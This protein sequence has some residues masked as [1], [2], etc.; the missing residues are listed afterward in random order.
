MPTNK[1]AN[2]FKGGLN[3][4]VDP[5]NQPKDTYSYALNLTKEDPVN[6]ADIVTNE[7]GFTSYLDLEYVYT[8]IGSVW[9]GLENYIL[10]IKSPLGSGSSFNRIIYLSNQ[11]PTTIYDNINLNFQESNPIKGTY[12]TNFKNQRIIYWVDGL[13]DDRVINVDNYSSYLNNVTELSLQVFYK[14][15]ILTSSVINDSG[16]SLA[17]GTLEFYGAYKTKDNAVSSWFRLTAN[18]LYII[19]DSTQSLSPS[20]Y[21]A[22]DGC[23]SGLPTNKSVTLNIS[24]LDPA[25]SILQIGVLK[26][27]GGN[28]KGF[29]VD[30]IYYSSS[31]LS[32]S[33][34]GDDTE[35]LVPD[36]S[37][38]VINPVRYYASNSIIQI[39][40]RLLRAN[41]S[42]NK[43]DIGYQSF[44]NNIV[45]DYYVQEELVGSMPDSLDYNIRQNWWKSAN[46]KYTGTK[47]LMRDEVYSVGIAF[48]LIK[49]NTESEVY[50]IPG[51][52]I[53][54]IPNTTYNN[55]YNNTSTI[56]YSSTWDTSSITENGITL[57]SWKVINTAASSLD[58]SVKKCAYWESSSMYPSNLSLPTTGSSSTGAGTTPIR[59][60]KIPNSGLEPIFRSTT[61]GGTINFYKRNIGLNFSN[62]QVPDSLKGNIAYIRIYIT[63]RNTANNKSIIAKGI[64]TNCALTKINIGNFSTVSTDLYVRPCAPYNDQLEVTNAGCYGAG[65]ANG[66]DTTHNYYHS[67]Y[68]PDT[69]LAQPQVTSNKVTIENEFTGTVQY[70][71]T[72]ASLINADPYTAGG[73]GHT[74]SSTTPG[75]FTGN[76]GYVRDIFYDDSNAG[77]TLPTGQT[78]SKLIYNVS[79]GVFRTTY[80]SICILNNINK[81]ATANSRRNTKQSVYVPFNANLSTSQL[82]NMDNPYISEYGASNVLVELDP[83]YNYLGATVTLDNSVAFQDTDA[84][85]NYTNPAQASNVNGTFHFH[86]INS[87]TAVYRYGSLKKVNSSQYGTMDGLVYI[88]TDTVISNPTFDAN[89]ILTTPLGGL[90]GDCWIDM[91]SV[92]RTRYSQIQTY[93]FGGFPEISIGMSTFFTESNI[94]HRLR[95]AEG[96]DYKQYYPKQ[97]LTTSIKQYLDAGFNLNI[98]NVDNYYKQNTDFNKLS[99]YRNYGLSQLD[100]QLFGITNYITRI[101]YSNPLLNESLVDNYR[102]YL[103]N[104]YIDLPKD[105]GFI[106]NMFKRSQELYAI[107]RD[108]LWR[109]Y[110]SNETIKSDTSTI[111]VGTGEFF[112]LSPIETLSIDGGFGGSS[113]KLS[114]AECP[115]GYFYVDKNKGKLILF[116]DRQ[117]YYDNSQQVDLS[118]LGIFEFIKDNFKISSP[119]IVDFDT[120]L[121]NNGYVA[122]YDPQLKRILVTRLDYQLTSAQKSAYRGIFNPLTSYTIGDVYFKNGQYYTYSSTSTSYSTVDSSSNLSDFTSG[123]IDTIVYTNTSPT[124]GTVTV[125]DNTTLTYTPTTNYTGADAFNITMNCVTTTV[126]VT[127]NASAP[128]SITENFRIINNGGTD[129]YVNILMDGVYQT[130]GQLASAFN[131]TSPLL[132][133]LN[134]VGTATSSIRL[135]LTS[136]YIPTTSQL[137]YR[138]GTFNGPITITGSSSS[139]IDFTNIDLTVTDTYEISINP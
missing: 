32:Y 35:I 96:T 68:S 67:F 16:G 124:H 36:I 31:T 126:N 28:S 92:K 120:P 88:P 13:N 114:L 24:N 55:Q 39:D 4:S 1:S 72:Q 103:A 71:R 119:T 84:N 8:L 129:L 60:H 82:A 138:N 26:T 93:T 59:H 125:V 65:Q 99:E 110:A 130:G 46:T 108:S 41:T 123:S 86:P 29:Y 50:H 98:F 22:I 18:P 118:Y 137:N 2:S 14:P 69:T 101:L 20:G 111:S 33:Y 115:Y 105:R 7:Q 78:S 53:N 89:N 135:V 34:T 10:F 121:L 63:P 109:V 40:N 19:H 58:G 95:Y 54:S 62:I 128:P 52:A 91:F 87:P 61:S 74:D 106:T 56:P 21:I 73:T 47:S 97:A 122:G 11:V 6:N 77:G 25:F 44:A 79:P 5:I 37:Q 136:G 90:I 70:Y 133:S 132:V 85:M 131:G 64:F 116:K 38:F 9:L 49:E 94:N 80:K 43:I 83:N 113:S 134:Y 104:N 75:G 48:G 42:S 81:V 15:A 3:L 112:S 51:R 17:T 57:P 27:E 100:A 30:N 76:T 23:D 117:S 45:S 66:W 139:I 12:R 102:I 127:I 107:T